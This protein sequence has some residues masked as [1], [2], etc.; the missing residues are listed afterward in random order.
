MPDIPRLIVLPQIS[1]RNSSVYEKPINNP[2]DIKLHE[3]YVSML[4][5][6]SQFI[7]L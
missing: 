1:P 4:N 6:D 5:T 3:L 7:L 2:S